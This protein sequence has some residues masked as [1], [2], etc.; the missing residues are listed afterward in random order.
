MAL[1]PITLPPGVVK[2][3]TPLQ[4]K[5]RFW[6]AN[7][8]RWRGGKL[9]PVGGWQR[10][11]STPLASTARTIFA[12]QTNDGQRYA[13]VGCEDNLYILESDNFTD[14]T[15]TGYVPPA[16]G[17]TGGYGAWNYGSLLYGDDTDPIDPRP[18]NPFYVPQFA[19]TMDNWGE[20]LLAVSSSDGRIL[21]WAEGETEAHPID[22]ID[23]VSAARVSNVITF[24]TDGH[25][26]FAPGQT[27]IVAGN[28]E[29]SFNDTWV[30]ATTPTNDTFT[31]ADSGTNQTGT[32]GTATAPEV[33]TNNAGILVTPERHAVC[34][35]ADGNPR[36]IAWSS[37]EDY[38]QWNFA[39]P[40]TTAGYLDI[41]SQSKVI[42][43]VTVR[44]GTLIWTDDEAW[45]MR[46]IGLPYIY[47]IERIGYG[48]GLMAPRSFATFAGRCVWMGKEGFWIYDGGV[49]KPLPCDV[50]AYVFDGIDPIAGMRFTHGSENGVFNEVW[51]WYPSV[52][53]DTPDQYVVYSY[54]EGWW[55]IGEMDRT[56]ACPAGVLDYPVAAD[57]SNEVYYQENGW[58]SAGIPLTNQRY[59]ETGTMNIQNGNRITMVRQAITDS[60]YG[61]DSTS[62]TVFTSFTPEGAESTFGP[63]SPRS[64]GYTDMRAS[65]REMRFKI[66][67][68]QD[69]EWSIGEMRVDLVPNGGR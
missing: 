39:D 50:G 63:F 9:L 21:H 34:W 19:W 45:L 32:G 16:S 28:T 36:R 2:L 11:T 6:D 47:A 14:V 41:D 26:G 30:I 13:A 8:I 40:A 65:G 51:F 66:T 18:V 55:S 10:I 1:V 12:W 52:G 27:V 37:R 42:M 46:Y 69:A 22:V 54:A 62:V 68:T 24:T 44:E 29:T 17:D 67:S 60:G 35:G 43:A 64:D 57:S 23:I 49:V 5:G 25:H 4:T 33:P 59:A 58:T 48:C 31:V 61:Y 7:L 53:S 15:P 3:A 20:D 38:T 56:A